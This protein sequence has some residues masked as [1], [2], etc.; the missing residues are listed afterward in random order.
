MKKSTYSRR[1]FLKQNVMAGTGVLLGSGMPA[2]Y[3]KATD[4]Q[5]SQGSLS[6]SLFDVD[7]TPPIGTHL[8]YEVMTRSWDMG[9]RAKGIVLH[10]AG[11][12]IVLCAIDWIGIANESYD[13]FRQVMAVAAGTKPE[14]VSIHAVHQHDAFRSDAGGERILKQHG[15][16]P[17]AWEGSFAREFLPTFG[18]AIKK[19][20]QTA[21]PV[22]HIGL[23]E[24][25]VY[26][27]ASNRRILGEDGRVR[28]NRM[29]SCKDPSLRAEPEGLIDPMVSLVSFWNED[30]PLAVLSYYA[31]HPMS[32]YRTGIAN[33][34]FPG[35]ARF[36]RQLAVPEALH[37]HF[38]GA[39]GNVAAGKYN[40]GSPANRL[41]LAE[42]LADGMKRAWENTQKEKITAGQVSWKFEP[43]AF[44]P[45]PFLADLKKQL[46][47]DPSLYKT[48]RGAA[49][50][51]AWYE[52]CLAGKKV[53]LCCLGIGKARILLLPGEL[54]VEYQLAA[55][56][57]RPDLFVAVAAYG[58]YSMGY[59]GTEK[60]YEEGGYEASEVASNVH[61]T[62]ERELKTAIFRLL[63]V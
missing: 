34:D 54:F 37:V 30:K 14:R 12:P 45:A 43:F 21:V 29:S 42:K 61:P 23:G 7:A 8:A 59:I 5:T 31:V 15:V 62:T 18:E 17:M 49:R 2:A 52:R 35:I 58:D 48:N 19:A 27:V 50:K 26:Q 57:K 4:K 39:A 11:E 46:A 32:Y 40:D 41:I 13:A 63:D 28:Q 6:L 36:M 56:Q 44:T 33:P 1:Y 38:T 9:L 55:R 24:A 3:A 53:D 47:A 16:E 25:P 22:T 10:G 20:V 60:A 51:M